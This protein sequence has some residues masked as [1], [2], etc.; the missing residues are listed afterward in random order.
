MS[1]LDRILAR[2]LVPD[3]LIRFGIRRLLESR[4]RDEGRFDESL[5]ERRRSE[6]AERIVSTPIATETDAANEQHY[7]VPPRFFELV[8]GP[9][10]KYSASLWSEGV[11]DLAA[12]EDAMI[13][14]YIDRAGIEDGQRI[15]E[16]GCGWGSLC[17]ALARRFPSSTVSAVSNS[18]PQRRFIESR[19][20]DDGLSNLTVFTEDINTFDLDTARHDTARP[21]GRFDRIVSIEMFEHVRNHR[22]LFER[23]AGWLEP[24]GKLFVHVF[25][26]LSLTYLFEPEDAGDWM[27]RH[28]FT[29]GIMPSADLLPEAASGHLTLE[30]QWLVNG[31]HYA[32]TA[33]AWLA[34]MDAARGEIEPLFATTYGPDQVRRWWA[35]WRVFF[36]ACEEL[37]AYRDGEEWMVAHYRFARAS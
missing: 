22:A 18:A 30:S 2:G 5:R 24:D 11:N 6:L 31:R 20:A 1:M 19:A 28:F 27:A 13:D 16:L 9:R 25:C 32:R 4:L 15:L 21:E 37:F 23:I 14:A 10:L 36:M 8:L 35:Y 3:P 12:A 29:G 17:L 33:A 26:H 34:A 7:E